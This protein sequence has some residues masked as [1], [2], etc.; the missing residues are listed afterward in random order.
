MSSPFGR[1][2]LTVPILVLAWIVWIA[3][4]PLWLTLGA[5]VD[6]ARGR[7]AL[8]LRVALFLT[9]YLSCEML[10]ILASGGLF[11]WGGVTRPV[12]ERWRDVHFRLEAWWGDM[13]FRAAVLSLDLRVELELEDGVDLGRG[14]FLL[15][16]RHASLADSLL[17][18]ALVSRPH[19]MHLRYVLKREL[20]W[21]PCLDIVGH[22]L[23]NAFVDRGSEL[24]E[25][26][27]E[28][29]AALGRDL[30]PHDGVL[31]YPEGTRFSA[32]KRAR[33]IA[34]LAEDGETERWKYASSLAC[35]LPPRP[36]GTLALLESAPEADVV[37]CSH[38][39][40]ED[41]AS[42]AALWSGAA[43]HQM[44]RV[45]LRRVPRSA[46]P[47]APEPAIAWLDDEWRRVDEWVS[48]NRSQAA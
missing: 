47:S 41:A 25:A 40:M 20:L 43:M 27:R 35:V 18:A 26:E 17:A 31:I 3:A 46:I 19:A 8:V 15:L 30:G 12:P 16:G 4:A 45:Q 44:V 23:P 13:L 6:V 24:P 34:R 48:A 1:R 7:G 5:I 29:V 10:G 9:I 11:V 28:R 22:R 21:G 37:V 32:A 39:G 42:P 38:T 36:G 2:L 14:P 33:V